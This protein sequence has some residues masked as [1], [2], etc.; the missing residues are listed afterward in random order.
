[1]LALAVRPDVGVVGA[2]LFYPD[3]TIQHA[4][5]FPRGDGHWVHGYRGRGPAERGDRGELQES[6]TVPAVT[7]ACLLIRRALFDRLGGFDEGLPVTYGDVDLCL[8]ARRLGLKVVITPRARLLHYEAVTRGYSTDRPGGE[9]LKQM[10]R[11][12]SG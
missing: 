3:G 4:G 12:P 2:T 8:R 11:F 6:R 1:M 9:H 10:E 5:L 7:G